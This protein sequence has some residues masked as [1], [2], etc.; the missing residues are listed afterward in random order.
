MFQHGFAACVLSPLSLY[1]LLEFLLENIYINKTG[2]INGPVL[3][4]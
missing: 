2:P 1:T 4:S 3:S